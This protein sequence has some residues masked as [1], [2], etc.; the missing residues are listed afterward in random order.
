MTRTSA[1]PDP[2]SDSGAA[3]S[4][5]AVALLE[6][7][8]VTLWACPQTAVTPITTRDP[9]PHGRTELELG[10]APGR[11]VVI[12]RATS[13]NTVPYLDP[14]YRATTMVPDTNRSVLLGND[15]TDNHVSR[16]HFTLRGAAGGAVVLTNGVPQAGGGI[17][18]PM[19]GTILMS[20]GARRLE[21][22]EEVLIR[23]G[24]VIAIR[25]P[26]DCVLQLKAV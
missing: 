20:A 4:L 5:C 14:V 26:N 24:E 10:L 25:L 2:F 3:S 1:I 11:L 22:A 13:E 18:P 7:P 15:W 19:N 17:R 16:A 8:P 6:G 23:C 9:R 21:P 12:G